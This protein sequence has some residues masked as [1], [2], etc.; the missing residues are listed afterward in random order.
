MK[1]VVIFGGDGQLGSEFQQRLRRLQ[2]PFVAADIAQCD[3]TKAFAVEHFLEEQ[4]PDLLINCA[5]YNQVD[6]AEDNPEAAFAVNAKAPGILARACAGRGIFLV[7]YSTD[8]VF[9]GT[10]GLLYTEQ[11]APNPLGVYG[12]SK[13]EGERQVQ[14]AGGNF[15]IF[16]L[17]WVIGPGQQNFLYKLRQWAE[18]NDTLKITEDEVSV[19]TFTRTVVDVTLAARS[20]GLKGLWHLTN[21]GQASRF[22]LATEF[23]RLAGIKKTLI[24]VPVSSFNLRALR[25]PCSAMS[26]AALAKALG[27]VIPDW[28]AG[29]KKYMSE[30][31]EGAVG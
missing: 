25:P 7:H 10:K 1:K 12:A 29:L 22:E 17:S 6:L 21:S 11:D 14:A 23:F 19:P 31:I 20:A 3:I 30:Q 16:R 15:L 24:P 13:L 18:K 5:A 28:R 2:V 26:S 27:I 4:K 9:D 8:Y